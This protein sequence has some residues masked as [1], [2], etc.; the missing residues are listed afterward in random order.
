[1]VFN[2][3]EVWMLEIWLF[4]GRVTGHGKLVENFRIGR[5]SVHSEQALSTELL[6]QK[7]ITNYQRLTPS[8]VLF[9]VM[10]QGGLFVCFSVSYHL[11]LRTLWFQKRYAKKSYLKTNDH[12]RHLIRRHT[13]V[14]VQLYTHSFSNYFFY[15]F[16]RYKTQKAVI[17]F[18]LQLSRFPKTCEQPKMHAH[19]P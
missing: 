16:I 1:M 13:Q 10:H 17:N 11:I 6:Q 7:F 14:R 4:G 15:S 3:S 5:N 12:V 8:V 18:F 19:F 2:L 9:E